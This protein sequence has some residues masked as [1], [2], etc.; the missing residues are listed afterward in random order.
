MAART[1]ENWIDALQA[2]GRYTFRRSDALAESGLSAEAVKKAL[3]RLAG[4]GRI[5]RLKE[6]F[7]AIVPLEHRS[8]GGPPPSWFIDDLMRAMELPYYVALLSAAAL[9]GAS[10]HQP[11]EFQVMTDRSVRPIAVGRSRIRFFVTKHLDCTPAQSMKT[12][13]GSMRV[14]TAEA[15]VL[16]LIRFAK[17]AGHLDHAATVVADLLP[18]I[19][20]R[21]LLKAVRVRADLPTAQRLGYLLD[22][23]HARRLAAPLRD[24]LGRQDARPV[25]LRTGRPSRDA[26]EDRRWQ[27]LVSTP[28]EIEA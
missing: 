5:A 20:A 25:P 24:W 28:L 12:P 1:L 6:Y 14:S 17:A 8:A 22:Q 23:L 27:V 15:T 4:R 13:T 11:Q 26:R 19:D 18:T 10:H 16:D 7:F 2:R 21:R 9:H 3:V